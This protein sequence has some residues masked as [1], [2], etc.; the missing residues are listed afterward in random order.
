LFQLQQ[1]FFQRR[2]VTVRFRQFAVVD[3]K[4]SLQSL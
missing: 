2:D 1:F 3:F 4:L